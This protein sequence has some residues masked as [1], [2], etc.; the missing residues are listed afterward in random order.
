MTLEG[1]GTLL[2]LTVSVGGAKDALGLDG[3][4]R[5]VDT[6]LRPLQPDAQEGGAASHERLQ[7]RRVQGHRVGAQ[8]NAIAS[9][10]PNC[11]PAA[12]ASASEIVPLLE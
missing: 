6:E 1:S 2:N 11:E 9:Y 4:E 7:E 10:E 12:V 5:S 8:P 3:A